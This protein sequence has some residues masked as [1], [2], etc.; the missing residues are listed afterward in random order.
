[1]SIMSA[2]FLKLNESTKS[3]KSNEWNKCIKWYTCFDSGQISQMSQMG[4]S[5]VSGLVDFIGPW[6]VKVK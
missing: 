4:L 5:D 6:D 3:I 2:T 1:M